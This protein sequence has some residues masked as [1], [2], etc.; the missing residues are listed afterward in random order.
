M[1]EAF[2]LRSTDWVPASAIV[3]R[4]DLSDERELRASG[5][6]PGLCTAFAISGPRGLRHVRCCTQPEFDAFYSRMRKHGIGELV[7][8]KRLLQARG[9][10]VVGNVAVVDGQTI[11]SEVA[12]FVATAE[13]VRP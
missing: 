7:R 10:V 5:D 8:A 1:I 13:E 2:L 9:K 12:P 3:A 4:Y 11:A 6:K